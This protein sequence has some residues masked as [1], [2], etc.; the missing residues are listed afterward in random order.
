VTTSDD[1]YHGAVSRRLMPFCGATQQLRPCGYVY[2]HPPS[3]PFGGRC[4][5]KASSRMAVQSSSVIG[6]KTEPN[7]EQPRES[8]AMV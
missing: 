8:F 4:T 6:W 5:W 1:W 3:I 2:R 7:A